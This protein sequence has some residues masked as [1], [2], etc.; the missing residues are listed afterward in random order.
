[1]QWVIISD[2]EYKITLMAEK[3]YKQ[4]LEIVYGGMR[5]CCQTTEKLGK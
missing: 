1:M 4:I 2:C 5:V 3:L